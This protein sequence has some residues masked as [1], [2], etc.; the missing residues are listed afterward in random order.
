MVRP[1]GKTTYVL[2]ECA[3]PDKSQATGASLYFMIPCDPNVGSQ[4]CPGQVNSLEGADGERN[5]V[6]AAGVCADGGVHNPADA[7]ISQL[8]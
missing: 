6:V 3:G 7:H 8:G 5:V 4:A 1:G 2:G